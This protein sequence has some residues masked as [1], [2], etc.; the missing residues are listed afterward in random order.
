MHDVLN[1]K[2]ITGCV[3][4]YNITPIDWFSK[5]QA[6]VET[7]TYGAEFVSSQSCIKQ[8]IDHC[9][10]LRYLGIPN[11]NI[12][13]IFRDNE[14]QIKSAILPHACLHKRHNIISCHFV[15]NMIACG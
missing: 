14:T 9:Q 2:A 8:I 11:Y 10:I 13:H 1:G 5:L 12:S 7:D 15:Q 6:T 4:F 3:H